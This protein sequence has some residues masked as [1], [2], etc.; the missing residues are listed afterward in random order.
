MMC[1]GA[2]SSAVQP[3]RH[4]GFPKPGLVS[5]ES[6]TN[7]C[8]SFPAPKLLC[9]CAHTPYAFCFLT[10][11]SQHHAE[12]D[13]TWGLRSRSVRFA[14]TFTIRWGLIWSWLRRKGLTPIL[15][16]DLT[17]HGVMDMQYMSENMSCSLYEVFATPIVHVCNVTSR[18]QVLRTLFYAFDSAPS[19]QGILRIT[20]PSSVHIS[21]MLRSLWNICYYG[22][23]NSRLSSLTV[24]V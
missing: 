24:I 4:Q 3:H 16:H 12:S 6:I 13:A 8:V 19:L 7:L 21:D 9:I 2:G 18:C 5:A 20:L 14:E 11:S 10:L 22:S 15:S 1:I 23:K 17:E